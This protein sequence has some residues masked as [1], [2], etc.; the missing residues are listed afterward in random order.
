MYVENEVICG[1]ETAKLTEC[2]VSRAHSRY[3]CHFIGIIRIGTCKNVKADKE[4][5]KYDT[6]FT[7][8][9]KK[10]PAHMHAISDSR[11]ARERQHRSCRV[12][13]S[14]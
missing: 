12:I 1:T 10:P 2:F 14:E 11:S 9:Y 5:E 8:K 6:L 4:T 3:I 13:I 7:A